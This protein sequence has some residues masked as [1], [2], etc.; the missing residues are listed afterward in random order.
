MG[1]ITGL[2]ISLYKTINEWDTD[3]SQRFI[4][5]WYPLSLMIPMSHLFGPAVVHVFLWLMTLTDGITPDS[6]LHFLSAF[7]PHYA[8]NT[9]CN[10]FQN[11]LMTFGTHLVKK[12][13]QKTPS[14]LKFDPVYDFWAISAQSDT[15]RCCN[16]KATWIQLNQII[17]CPQVAMILLQCKFTIN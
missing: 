2:S 1:D 7:G 12:K 3:K 14:Q 11:C 16:R 9:P 6:F 17:L 15:Y 10:P 5:T 8:H 13:T 4:S